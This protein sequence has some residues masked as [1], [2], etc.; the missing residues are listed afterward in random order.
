[1]N[2][3]LDAVQAQI[4]SG[5]MDAAR[6]A[7]DTFENRWEA[8]EDFGAGTVARLLS[9][10]EDAMRTLRDALYRGSGDPGS[11]LTAL[12]GQV[13]ATPRAPVA[14]PLRQRGRGGARAGRPQHACAR[15]PA[16]C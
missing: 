12:R 16:W 2:A 7:Y 1:M 13:G 3:A 10:I 9:D 14:E 5:D 15:T 8:I 6:R 4:N 11:A